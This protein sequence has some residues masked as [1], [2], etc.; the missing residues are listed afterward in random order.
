[1]NARHPYLAIAA[2]PLTHWAIHP[3]FPD[4][5]FEKAAILVNRKNLDG[6]LATARYQ[7]I[8]ET[9]RIEHFHALNPAHNRIEHANKLHTSVVQFNLIWRVS[10][11]LLTTPRGVLRVD[12]WLVLNGIFWVL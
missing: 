4:F 3:A 1:M 6:V 8:R 11:L 2:L 12:G 5:G 7:P 10:S 9:D